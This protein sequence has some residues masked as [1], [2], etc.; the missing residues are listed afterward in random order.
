MSHSDLG[1]HPPPIRSSDPAELGPDDIH[2]PM[3][4]D[5]REAAQPTVSK[6]GWLTTAADGTQKCA[7]CQWPTYLMHWTIKPC[8]CGCRDGNPTQELDTRSTTP[9]RQ[10]ELDTNQDQPP[11]QENP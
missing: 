8:T 7:V 6:C 10:V 2:C 5:G 3:W 1:E 11:D 4:R 9:T